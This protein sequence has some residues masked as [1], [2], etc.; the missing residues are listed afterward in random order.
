M[1]KRDKGNGASQ[2]AH[3]RDATFPPPDFSG[4]GSAQQPDPQTPPVDWSAQDAALAEY[5]RS[6]DD[7]AEEARGASQTT[8]TETPADE[9]GPEDFERHSPARLIEEHARDLAVQEEVERRIKARSAVIA[10]RALD[11][12]ARRGDRNPIVRIGTRVFTPRKRP[13]KAGGGVG[14]AEV[15]ERHE[16]S[17]D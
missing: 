13:A 2:E 16:T 12:A 8:A 10:Q 14:L 4:N 7:G 9:P 1:G 5:H 15:G 6:T 3:G 17:L 11:S